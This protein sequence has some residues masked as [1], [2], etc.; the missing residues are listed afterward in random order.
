MDIHNHGSTTVYQIVIV[1]GGTNNS[2]EVFNEK[3]EHTFFKMIKKVF[4]Y[5]KKTKTFFSK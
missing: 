3:E 4:E 1:N 5:L 2:T